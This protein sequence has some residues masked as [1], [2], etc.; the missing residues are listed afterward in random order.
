MMTDSGIEKVAVLGTGVLGGQIAWHSA[1]KGKQVV[2]YN[3]REESLSKIRVAH[4]KLAQI[5]IKDV[6]ASTED[7]AS[8][9]SRLSYVSDLEVAVS[10]ADLV[11]ESLPEITSIKTQN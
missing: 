7:I 8:T 4:D 6:G 2:A 1:F 5:Y 10:D 11:I 9:K 3:R